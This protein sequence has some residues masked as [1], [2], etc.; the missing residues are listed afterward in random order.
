MQRKQH[1]SRRV[2][3][4]PVDDPG[5][6]DV[7]GVGQRPAV[8]E[9]RVDERV[10]PVAGRRMDDEVGRLVDREELVV[11]VD[12]RERDVAGHD[13]RLDVPGARSCLLGE[14]HGEGGRVP[15]EDPLLARE[16]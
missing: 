7:V 2:L 13:L 4:D 14:Q 16:E 8:M 12:D 1:E 11:L 5:T 6:V 10:V 3:V 15:R 9:E